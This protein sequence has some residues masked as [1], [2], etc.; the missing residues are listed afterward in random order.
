MSTAIRK[1]IFTFFLWIKCSL[2]QAE[3]D[4]WTNP[5]CKKKSID[6]NKTGKVCV[7]A[8]EVE[9]PGWDCEIKPLK[10]CKFRTFLIKK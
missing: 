8:A 4:T 3:K 5:F 7:S 10:M 9:I 2:N 6:S 1:S